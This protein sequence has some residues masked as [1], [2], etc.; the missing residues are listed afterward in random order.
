MPPAELIAAYLAGP[1]LVRNAVRGLSRTDLVARPVPWKWSCLE[2]VAHLADFDPIYV[3]RMKRCVASENPTVYGADE[4][5]FAQHLAYHDRDID[6]E[7][8]VL[9]ATRAAF[10]RVLAALPASAFARPA[11]HDERGPMT[12][13]TMLT[14]ITR[15]ITHHLPFVAAKRAALGR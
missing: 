7:L 13:E 2:V 15:H 1:A 11:T 9:D 12:L 5:S 4:N 6:E 8:A 3:D 14:A 10:G